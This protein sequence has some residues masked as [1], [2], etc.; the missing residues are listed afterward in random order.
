MSPTLKSDPVHYYPHHY[1]QQSSRSSTMWLR[2]CCFHFPTSEKAGGRTHGLNETRHEPPYPMETNNMGQCQKQYSTSRFLDLPAELRLAI[3]KLAME[4]LIT[5]LPP[6]DSPIM[7]KLRPRYRGALALLHTNRSIRQESAREMLP[8]I[9]AHWE[10]LEAHARSFPDRSASIS[11]P[12]Y[13]ENRRYKESI[14][15]D[16]AAHMAANVRSMLWMV[17]SDSSDVA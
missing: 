12:R 17:I 8:L 16:M 9:Q 10:K 2:L 13:W 7:A 1:P 3:Y 14:Y 4:D 5:T 15:A 6:P 11:L